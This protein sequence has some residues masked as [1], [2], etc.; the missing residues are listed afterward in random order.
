MIDEFKVLTGGFDKSS[1]VFELDEKN[2]ESRDVVLK[3]SKNK[4][5]DK[6]L[7]RTRRNSKKKNVKQRQ[8]M[9][10]HHGDIYCMEMFD[11]NQTF[12][13]GS[14]DQTIKVWSWTS[15]ECLRT[16]KG[17]EDVI[18][19][20]CY[21]DG[22]LFSGSLDRKIRSIITLTPEWN[23]NTGECIGIFEG[24]SQWIKTI[25]ATPYFLVSGGWDEVIKIWSKDGQCLQ[26]IALNMGPVCNIQCDQSKIVSVCREEGFQHQLAIVDFGRNVYGTLDLYRL[27]G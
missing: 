23:V 11:D 17:H 18:T 24:H 21:M 4:F 16:L 8:E 7:K 25:A 14:T 20:L 6:F 15:G 19:D 22:V 2:I 26:S 12:A 5:W 13:T 3:G 27:L 9:R 1:K 10:G